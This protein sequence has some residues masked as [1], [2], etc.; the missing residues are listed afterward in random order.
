MNFS[1][2]SSPSR[3]VR[4]VA[5]VFSI[6]GFV[7]ACGYQEPEA[8]PLR[9]LDVAEESSRLAGPLSE[10][11]AQNMEDFSAMRSLLEL[12][13]TLGT[14]GDVVEE[15]SVDGGGE[16]VPGEGGAETCTTDCE[17]NLSPAE[18]RAEVET[19]IFEK[20]FLPE[21][22][23]SSTATS[24]IF[25]LKGEIFCAP[26]PTAELMPTEEELNDCIDR[27]DA[28][29]IRLVV[30]DP[31]AGAD[32]LD[33]TV[34]AG[35]AR[36][37]VATLVLR[38]GKAS[39][40]LDLQG[41]KGF[42]E[43]L[44]SVLGEFGDDVSTIPEFPGAFSG[45]LVLDIAAQG[46]VAST[47]LGIEEALS[48]DISLEGGLVHLGA[49]K[50]EPAVSIDFDGA[51][52][53]AGIDVD[54]G[55]LDASGPYGLFAGNPDLAGELLWH[56]GGLSFALTLDDLAG[57]IAFTQLGLGET[58]TTLSLDRAPVFSVDINSEVGRTFDMS[59]EELVDEGTSLWTFMPSLEV[60]AYFGL[61]AAEALFLPAEDA[62]GDG[63]I[64]PATIPTFLDNDHWWISVASDGDSA[65]IK[66]I[67]QTDTHDGTFQVT[68]GTLQLDTWEE[69]V[70]DSSLLV[71]EAGQCL[72]GLDE[73]TARDVPS[74][75]LRYLD[76]GVCP[77]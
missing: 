56:L 11:F 53:F 68:H 65:S 61:S 8:L 63:T 26:D 15:G 12:S 31:N 32:G 66:P 6:F 77:E 10:D 2:L 3:T 33:I 30:E 47:A 44:R 19:M 35:E 14:S 54:L 42:V 25:L 1:F 62:A 51:T 9:A 59:I 29:A 75:L 13:N 50:A 22:L 72:V 36:L 5:A 58:T 60:S 34:Q 45:V 20:L 49:A 18:L 41:L 28:L 37:G 24:A 70:T 23:E 74:E 69:G 55:A 4:Q 27:F 38:P 7:I 73:T 21:Q 64:E 16:V 67:P 40:R 17:V 52:G 57:E 71:I 48:V 46:A 39:L 76:A 43:H